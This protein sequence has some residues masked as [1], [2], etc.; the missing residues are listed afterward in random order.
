MFRAD[1]YGLQSSPPVEDGAAAQTALLTL[2]H[3]AMPALTQR[4]TQ[5]SF[6]HVA[7]Y[8]EQDWWLQGASDAVWAHWYLQTHSLWLLWRELCAGGKHAPR[9]P[10]E[11]FA[12]V[13]ELEREAEDLWYRWACLH[14][15]TP[16]YP[17][18]EQ[19]VLALQQ[20]LRRFELLRDLELDVSLQPSLADGR[21]IGRAEMLRHWPV[22]QRAA[23][24]Q[25]W[26]PLRVILHG[27]QAAHPC[28][29]LAL[30]LI[31]QDGERVCCYEPLEKRTLTLWQDAQQFLLDD[32]GSIF[33]LHSF[34]PLASP[35]AALLP[36]L[37]QRTLHYFGRR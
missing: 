27:P 36:S 34:Y 29:S 18:P 21:A 8:E 6:S 1:I 26:L 15:G 2:W 30:L 11:P 5:E 10:A 12:R 31:A 13:P 19:V 32:A 14:A 28:R 4:L 22:L 24:Q 9:W 25:Q 35:I 3:Q 37:W 16:D 17:H 20:W 33:M 23:S 7:Q